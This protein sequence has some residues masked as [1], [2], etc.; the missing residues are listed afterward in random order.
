MLLDIYTHIYP[1]RYFDAMLKRTP[2]L[3]DMGKRLRSVKKLLDLDVRFREMDECGDY[4]QVICL[5]NPP[6][7]D[8][9]TGATGNE[10]A[11]IAN[12]SLAELCARYPDRFPAFVAAVSLHDVDASVR[13][14]ERAFQCGARG[15]QIYTNVAGKPLDSGAYEE[16][17]ALA[18]KHDLPIWL[19]PARTAAAAD[20]ASEERSRFEMWW[21]FGW[22]YEN[23]G[24]YV[25]P[26]V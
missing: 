26:G 8:I 6:I 21:C 24:R 10:L 19:H 14:V 7:E 20:Y 3:E 12:D 15:F 23:V 2:P 16:V 9:S 18:A 11:T 1:Q 5:P 13:E 22:P 4:R 17:F 25:P